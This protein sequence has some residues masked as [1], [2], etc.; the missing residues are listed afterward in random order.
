MN[1][2][3]N[4]KHRLKLSFLLP[5]YWGIWL[6]YGIL[7]LIAFLPYTTKIHLGENLGK[8]IYWIAGNRKKVALKNLKTAFPEKDNDEINTLLFEHFKSLGVTLVEFTITT[9]GRHRYS[10]Q[11]NETRYF[12]TVLS[13][14]KKTETKASFFWFHTLQQPKLQ[15]WWFLL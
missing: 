6:G 13:T 11:D 4:S 14:L 3:N 7:R 15:D 12:T 8:F 10:Q 1:S 9:W 2:L 5:K